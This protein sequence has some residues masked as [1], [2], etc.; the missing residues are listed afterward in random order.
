MISVVNMA[1]QHDALECRASARAAVHNHLK[2]TGYSLEFRP[3]EHLGLISSR[4]R[5]WIKKAFHIFTL[6]KENCKFQREFDVELHG[7]AM[8][9]AS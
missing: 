5:H 4:I 1:L 7:T 6:C 2:R 8:M 9:I 3:K